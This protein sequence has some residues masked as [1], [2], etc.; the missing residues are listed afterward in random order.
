[1]FRKPFVLLTESAGAYVNGI[2]VA[3]SRSVSSVS[4]SVQPVTVFGQDM[5]AMAEGR[6]MSDFVKV[7]SDTRLKVT[8]DGKN[9]Q[10]DII[11]SQGFGYELVSIFANQ[12]DVINHYKYVAVKVFKYTNSADWTS[13]ALKRAQQ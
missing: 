9:I 4:A 13:G 1:M 11:V 12:S 6:H 5:Q 10:P 2:W 7:Y 8:D 3:G